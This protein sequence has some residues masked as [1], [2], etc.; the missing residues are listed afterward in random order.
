MNVFKKSFLCY[1]IF[2]MIIDIH[3]HG[4]GGYDTRS[5]D[6]EHILRIA[7]LHGASGV[8]EIYLTIFPATIK[9]MRENMETIKQA[10]AIQQSAGMR[11][12]PE[13][14][15]SGPG[16]SVDHGPAR[17]AGVHLEGPFLNPSKCG[18]LNAMVLIDPTEYNYDQLI[19][20]FP[21]IIKIITMAPELKGAH[22]IIKKAADKGFIISMGHSDATFA[23]AAL[24]HAAGARGITHLFN[25]MHPLH[26]REPG[27]AGY[28]LMNQDIYVEIITDS[29]HLHPV[30]LE[31][32]FRIKDNDRIIIVSDSVIQTVKPMAAPS[33]AEGEGITDNN[34]RLLGGALTVTA[35]AA[36]ISAHFG[37]KTAENCI[38]SNPA[39]YLGT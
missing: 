7:E 21:D 24:G 32:I 19:E 18:G 16:P 38:S 35:A 31:L 26:H 5:S 10:I 4:I 9:V 8:D 28:G 17:I 12:A 14:S 39:R 33:P 3:T 36:G 20:G 13:L 22:K 2:I 25:A 30:T 29:F 1:Y 15:S 37:E 27:I 6:I 34:G 11:P 23:E